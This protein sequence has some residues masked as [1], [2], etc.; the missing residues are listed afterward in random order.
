MY[1]L[2]FYSMTKDVKA[3]L[4]SIYL[5]IFLL[6]RIPFQIAYVIY[7]NL[8]KYVVV[9]LLE[10]AVKQ[11]EGQMASGSALRVIDLQIMSRDYS[12]MK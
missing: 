2:L 12:D 6:H 7:I 11:F 3:I 9:G 4:I 8:G 10:A 5:P 1:M